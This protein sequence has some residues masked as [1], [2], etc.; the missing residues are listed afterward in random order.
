M[1]AC[2]VGRAARRPGA[3]RPRRAQ[4]QHA[5]R[6]LDGDAVAVF[7]LFHE[8][9][10]D[11]D[12]DAALRQRGDGAPERAPR[13]RVDAAGRFVQEQ[14]LRL[15]QQA[16]RHGQALLVAAGQQAA[17]RPGSRP[18]W[19][20]IAATRW[21]RP[22]RAGRRRRRRIP[23]SRARSGCRTA[24]TSATHSRCARA[25]AR[26]VRRF[27]PAT[28]RWPLVAG[29]SP[30]SMRKVVVLPAPF[31]PSR[32]KIS[33]RATSNEVLA[34]AVKSPKRR[35]RSRTTITGP[36]P[37]FRRTRTPAPCRP[38]GRAPYARG[39]AGVLV[40]AQHHHERVFQLFRPRLVR[41][42]AQ[43]RVQRA[44]IRVRLADG[45]PR[46]PWAPRP[47]SARRRR[48]GAPAGRARACPAA[49]WR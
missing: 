49:A 45:A 16:G 12:G 34:T 5:A 27:R 28:S 36:S 26:A 8:V 21:R 33:P 6:V 14:D 47:R 38:P 4:G 23:G 22:G 42:A 10:G 11:D 30:H 48:S 37:P 44:R 7:R 1:K 43:Q 35:T 32:P 29:S 19:S 2:H 31:G 24:R 18:N 20:T 40:L 25:W 13:Q 15:V 9:R 39:R 41:D 17:D 46:R 3:H